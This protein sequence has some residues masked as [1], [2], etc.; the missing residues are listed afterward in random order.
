MLIAVQKM[1]LEK[2]I[3]VKEMEEVQYY[4]ARL[5]CE[6]SDLKVS[7]L[8]LD[9]YTRRVGLNMLD[10]FPRDVH[11]NQCRAKS[12]NFK[13]HHFEAINF[14]RG[15]LRQFW[16]IKDLMLLDEMLDILENKSVIAIDTELDQ[17]YSFHPII[18]L[19]QISCDSHDFIIDAIELHAYIESRLRNI[20]LSPKLLKIVFSPNDIE[21]FKRDFKL[22]MCYSICRKVI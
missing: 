4:R 9:S 8:D 1:N 17:E 14:V 5:H 16:E 15:N 13:E 3:E 11:P 20:L 22:H 6:N 12:F 21:S 2:V 10:E 7:S 18:S 19:I